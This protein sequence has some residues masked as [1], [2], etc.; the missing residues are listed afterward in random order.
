MVFGFSTTG[1]RLY[2][3]SHPKV[4]TIC[5][6]WP[7]LPLSLSIRILHWT[8]GCTLNLD[9]RS[10]VSLHAFLRLFIVSYT[11]TSATT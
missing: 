7:H 1:G 8:I 10:W 11:A 9:L 6:G 5:K 3:F 4:L 2:E